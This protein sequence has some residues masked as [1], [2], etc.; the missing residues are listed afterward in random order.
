MAVL[1]SLHV[2]VVQVQGPHECGRQ[3]HAH[4]LLVRGLQGR[5]SDAYDCLS[6]V[7]HDQLPQALV[8]VFDVQGDVDG[9]KQG[10]DCWDERL[11]CR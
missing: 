9:R 1:I 7:Q 2:I 8:H 4:K 3:A 11:T 6:K 5:G 10:G